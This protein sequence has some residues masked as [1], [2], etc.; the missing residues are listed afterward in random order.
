MDGSLRAC[1]VL[2]QAL[3]CLDSTGDEALASLGEP[4]WLSWD[5]RQNLA[6]AEIETS[7]VEN[8]NALLISVS[9]LMRQNSDRQSFQACPKITH[10][11]VGSLL[12]LSLLH[13]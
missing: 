5:S 10:V 3:S 11:E 8:P 1:L 12:S 2:R 6:G 9:S 7:K 13:H 4:I